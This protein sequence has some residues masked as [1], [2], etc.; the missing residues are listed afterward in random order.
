MDKNSYVSMDIEKL[1]D[2]NRSISVLIGSCTNV[3]LKARNIAHTRIL[4]GFSFRSDDIFY[5]EFQLY[6]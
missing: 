3:Q 1:E 2:A 5:F 6:L 4:M